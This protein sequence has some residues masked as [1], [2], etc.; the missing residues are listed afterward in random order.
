MAFEV[1]KFS[2]TDL[3]EIKSMFALFDAAG[4]GAVR[5]A[6]VGDMLRALNF[7]PTDGELRILEAEYE[8]NS[9]GLV[10]QRGFLRILG[11]ARKVP[12]FVREEELREMLQMFEKEHHPG[13]VCVCNCN[14]LP[15]SL[16]AHLRVGASH[17]YSTLVRPKFSQRRG[18]LLC[19]RARRSRCVNCATF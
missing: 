18:W 12:T 8:R 3:N 10:D 9:N 5:V 17:Q 16:R 13:E 7:H 4:A 2:D 14:V 6:D 1:N 11:R 19:V 15:V